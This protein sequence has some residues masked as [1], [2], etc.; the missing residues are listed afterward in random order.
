M[1]PHLNCKEQ[2]SL[3]LLP[4]KITPKSLSPVSVS[5]TKCTIN[6]KAPKHILA[7]F[8]KALPPRNDSG[9]NFPLNDSDSGP[10]VGV[11]G[12][13]SELQPGRPPSS[14]PNRPEKAKNPPLSLL[15]SS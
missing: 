5:A 14:E 6:S 13:K 7:G 2:L 4:K 15:E 3:Y 9:A 8:K 10:K 11:T 12:Q 1:Q